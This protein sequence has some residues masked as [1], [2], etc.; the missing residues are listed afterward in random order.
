MFSEGQI[1]AILRRATKLSEHGTLRTSWNF[2]GAASRDKRGGV[3]RTQQTSPP[4]S[5]PSPTR[6]AA[7]CITHPDLLRARSGGSRLKVIEQRDH[8]G[9]FN[10][11][12]KCKPA[13][14]ALLRFRASLAAE[15]GV[16]DHSAFG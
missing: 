4:H 12:M 14:A 11:G 6:A 5:P 16:A 7:R 9:Q 1:V 13:E 3:L 15:A 2:S 8:V 10:T